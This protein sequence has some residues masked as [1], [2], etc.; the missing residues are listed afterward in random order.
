MW[1][2]GTATGGEV[3]HPSQEDPCYEAGLAFSPEGSTLAAAY[4]VYDDATNSSRYFAEI[5][6]LDATL[7]GAADGQQPVTTAELSDRVVEVAFSPNG[8]MAAF[9]VEDGHIHIESL[10][11]GVQP[12][13]LRHEDDADLTAVAF[14]PHGTLLASATDAGS[15]HLWM[16]LER[17]QIASLSPVDGAPECLA[18]SPD[19]RVLAV[20]TSDGSIVVW[21]LAENWTYALEG[22]DEAV[23]SVAFSPD[24]KVLASGSEDGTMRLWVIE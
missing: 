16:V 18:F 7:I 24:G 8:T 20:G 9:G 4:S 14:G 2:I 22:H 11:S 3:F 5:W 23:T 12:V 13:E 15:V 19:G 21:Q 10:L 17:K 1:V 6:L